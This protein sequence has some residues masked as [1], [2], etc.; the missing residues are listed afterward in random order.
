M[1]AP[2]LRLIFRQIHSQ[3]VSAALANREMDIAITAGGLTARGLSREV[4]GEGSYACLLDGASLANPDDSLTLDNYVA[5]EHLLVSS[6]G[7]VGIVDE[8]LAALALKRRVIASTTHFAALPYLLK[9]SNAIATVPDHAAHAIAALS[10]LRV[11]QCPLP[12]PR[13]PIELGWRTN[14]LRDPAV[15][16]VRLAIAQCFKANSDAKALPLVV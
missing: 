10:G 16:K 13:Y 9:G 8:G 1:L 6:G 11:L 4:L 7:I 2:R 3:I 14:A 12:L 15:V 5:R